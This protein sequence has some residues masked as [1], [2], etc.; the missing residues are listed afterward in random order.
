ME[1]EYNPI[2]LA[3]DIINHSDLD[4]DYKDAIADLLYNVNDEF[5]EHYGVKGMRKG[6]RRWTNEDGTLTEA[7]KQHYGIGLDTG[8]KEN[9]KATNAYREAQRAYAEG[10]YYAR[11]HSKNVEKYDNKYAETQKEKYAKK[12]DKEIERVKDAVSARNK[13]EALMKQ[14]EKSPNFANI[15]SRDREFGFHS[16][17][18]REILSKIPIFI[19]LPTGFILMSN[20]IPKDRV[21]VTKESSEPNS[22]TPSEYKHDL[23]IIEQHKQ[24]K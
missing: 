17:R 12:Y 22:F 20:T 10:E 9:K 19:P 15:D 8:N 24:K 21:L 18:G 1:E 2:K 11:L 23:K 16:S 14:I 5:L 7:G 4:D 6:V 3:C 13:G